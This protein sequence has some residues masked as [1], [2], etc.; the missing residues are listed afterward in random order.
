MKEELTTGRVAKMMG[1]SVRTLRYYDQIGLLKPSTTLSNGRRQYSKEDMLE[2][3]KIMILKSAQF[4]LEHIKTLRYQLDTINI[5]EMH[6][7]RLNSEI[8]QLTKSLQHTN[9]LLNMYQIEGSLS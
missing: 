5:I 2:L 9:T 6:K 3:E 4:S 8:E 7:R 1:I